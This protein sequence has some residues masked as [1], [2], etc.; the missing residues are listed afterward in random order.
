MAVI[1]IESV[2]FVA[3]LAAVGALF[4]LVVIYFTPVGLRLR[5][6]QNRKRVVRAAELSCPV[7]GVHDEASLV[8]LPSGERLCPECFKEAFDV[9]H[10]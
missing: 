5:Q 4:F 1:I 3:L 9:Q 6:N 2:L 10:D 7:H 8:R